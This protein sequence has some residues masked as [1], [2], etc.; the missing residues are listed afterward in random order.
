VRD[1]S[2]DGD[3]SALMCSGGV[4]LCVR[5][6]AS[7]FG[8]GPD[9]ELVEDVGETVSDRVRAE[10]EGCGGFAVG[11]SSSDDERDL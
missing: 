1:D 5:D 2:E 6:D 9:A 11:C 10:E 4:G 8:A 7:E 3:V